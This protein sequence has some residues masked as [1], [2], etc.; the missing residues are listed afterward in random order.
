MSW[1]LKLTLIFDLFFLD[2]DLNQPFL[3]TSCPWFF[4][5]RVL[6]DS[7]KDSSSLVNV[8][9]DLESLVV[10]G[11]LGLSLGVDRRLRWLYS[12]CKKLWIYLDLFRFIYIY[13]HISSFKNF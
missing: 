5:V 1:E 7:Q 12:S 2:R 9:V 11:G 4:L 10:L 8:P 6:F 3:S 13:F